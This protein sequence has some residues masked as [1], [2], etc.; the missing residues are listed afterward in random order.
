MIFLKNILGRIWALWGI[1]LFVSTMLVVFVFFLP[2]AVLQEP[3]RA[4]WHRQ[5]SKVWMYV[6]LHLI[7]CPIRI[8][9]KEIFQKGENYIVVCNHNTLMDVP[10][11]T[12]FLPHANKT[13][14]KSSFAKVPLFGWIYSWGSILVNRKDPKS[15]AHSYVQMAKALNEWHLD[16]VLFPEGTRNKT[17]NPLGDFQDG[18]FKLAV[19]A[20][21]KII[22]VILFNSKKILP[23]NKRF[24]LWPA[25]LE[26]HIMPAHTP[27]GKAA[28][29]LKESI[30]REMW[31]YIEAY[32]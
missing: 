21:K 20:N 31:D 27:Q 13:L 16:M 6:Y 11:T 4:K 32:Q 24:F 15:R 23:S 30:Y 7:G 29:E 2:C 25:V 9:N 17:K 22:P 1:L 28:K 3:N 10:V 26:L 19:Q 12:P 5:V 8:R 14:A 18:A